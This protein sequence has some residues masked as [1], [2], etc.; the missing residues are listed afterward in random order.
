MASDISK[1]SEYSDSIAVQIGPGG[2]FA[3][4]PVT[5]AGSPGLFPALLAAALFAALA[6]L[7]G[8]QLSRRSGRAHQMAVAAGAVPLADAPPRA[9][10]IAGPELRRLRRS[11]RQK[12][13]LA[14]SLA[15]LL[16]SMPEAL[17]W[18]A[19]KA[20]ADVG[21]QPVIPDGEPFDA[22]VHYAV[23]TEPVPP[24]GRE[25]TVARTVRP[26]YADGE[27]ILVYPKVVVYA[28]DPDGLSR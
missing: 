28:D 19:E 14:R 22:A 24:G 8:A 3:V 21:V 1:A 12:A 25:N 26:G 10:P 9:E 6:G 23:G 18:Q 7:G 13:I 5:D 2:A 20:L 27:D 17:A 11:A 15:E 16:P 4:A